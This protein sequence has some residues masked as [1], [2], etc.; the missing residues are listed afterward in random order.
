MAIDMPGHAKALVF[1]IE[2]G[3]KR[4]PETAVNR[5]GFRQLAAPIDN[6]H[7]F[8]QGAGQMRLNNVPK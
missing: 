8:K 7:A 5:T 2:T 3:S 4:A 6:A 1:F